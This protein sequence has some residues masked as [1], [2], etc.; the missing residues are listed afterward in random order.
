MKLENKTKNTK[1][2]QLRV[3]FLKK[4]YF[5]V[6]IKTYFYTLVIIMAKNKINTLI[7]LELILTKLHSTI[8]HPDTTTYLNMTT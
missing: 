6:I 5:I 7:S 1:R 3:Q 2:I 8:I 4:I